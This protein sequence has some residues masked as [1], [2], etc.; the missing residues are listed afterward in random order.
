MNVLILIVFAFLGLAGGGVAA[1][2]NHRAEAAKKARRLA[3]I[4]GQTQ[5]GTRTSP[6]QSA[7]SPQAQA[8]APTNPAEIAAKLKKAAREQKA[9]SDTKSLS[10]LILQTGLKLNLTKFWVISV[11]FGSGATWMLWSTSLPRIIVLLMGFTAFFGVPRLFLKIKANRRQRA[12]L[13]DFADALESMIRLLKAGMPVGEAIAMVGREFRGP[14]GDEMARVYDEQ[15]VGVPLQDAVRRMVPRMPLAEVQMFATSIAIQI[16]TG[17]SLSEVLGNLAGVIRARY[18]LK[19]K[20]QALSAEA[21]ISAMIIGALPVL[22]SLALWA[23]NPDY[24]GLLFSTGTGK[25]LFSGICVWM[26]LGIITMR[27]MINF[28][29]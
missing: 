26:S 15:R 7:T 27:Q 3:V 17:S 29:V 10:S 23:V 22:V 9:L 12:F 18:R 16:Q 24:I 5:Q 21:K 6:N 1:L 14:V 19:R 8:G 28:K 25:M 4:A 11:V 20:V 2:I 13:D